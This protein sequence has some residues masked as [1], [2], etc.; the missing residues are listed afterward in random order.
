M[1][2]ATA[3]KFAPS[4]TACARVSRC[5]YGR[6]G[7]PKG[8]TGM[9]R[10]RLERTVAGL[11]PLQAAAGGSSTPESENKYFV[12]FWKGQIVNLLGNLVLAAAALTVARGQEAL[13]K[14]AL[15]A[16]LSGGPVFD[17][18]RLGLYMSCA[19]HVFVATS[20]RGQLDYKFYTNLLGEKGGLYTYTTLCFSSIWIRFGVII[21]CALK[22]GGMLWNNTA[23]LSALLAIPSLPIIYAYFSFQW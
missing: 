19:F 6:Q 13:T 21:V 16:S 18:F 20:W 5:V 7:S 8:V 11:T 9:G 10:A 23:M 14:A 22:T 1:A 12:P 2:A 4:R 17:W 3:V 15:L